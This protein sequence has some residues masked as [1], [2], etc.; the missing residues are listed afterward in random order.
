ME[1]IRLIHADASHASLLANLA[2]DTF[3]ESFE[4][5]NNPQDFK[6][7]TTQA[8]TATQLEKEI[9]ESGSQYIL[10]YANNELAGYARVRNS[11]EVND[12]FPDQKTLELH[13]IYVLEKFIGQG[14]GQAL[15]NY[16]L[17]LA[18]ERGAEII[19]L[20]VWEHNHRAQEFYKKLG[21]EYFGSHTFMMG[22]DPQTDL[23][24]KL[25]LQ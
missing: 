10:A 5:V 23:L 19:W 3:R 14:V 20:G 11:D 25:N 17:G 15:M 1:R 8:F 18:K 7:Y 4:K 12:K 16:C 9:H 2:L 21:F 13:R 22:N 24:M 6:T